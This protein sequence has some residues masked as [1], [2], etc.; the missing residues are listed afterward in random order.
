[1][2]SI[3]YISLLLLSYIIRIS[4]CWH[5]SFYLTGRALT[6]AAGHSTSCH[7]SLPSKNVCKQHKWHD[8]DKDQRVVLQQTQYQPIARTVPITVHILFWDEEKIVKP[9][10]VSNLYINFFP[11]KSAVDSLFCSLKFLLMM[12]IGRARHRVARQTRAKWWRVKLRWIDS[13]YN[14]VKKKIGCWT[15]TTLLLWTKTKQRTNDDVKR[16]KRNL[17]SIK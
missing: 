16:K 11:Y 5:V 10:K 9:L 13:S 2:A 7:L 3:L 14:R 6:F 12:M 4:T 17:K 1:M 15:L 8:M